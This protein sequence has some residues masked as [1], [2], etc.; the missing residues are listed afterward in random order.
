[1][2]VRYML[3]NEREE[4]L[5]PGNRQL[6][7]RCIFHLDAVHVAQVG[8]AALCYG[9]VVERRAECCYCGG[10]MGYACLVDEG[11]QEDPAE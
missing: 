8:R 6:P 9:H 7:G 11:E 4:G 3:T 2:G 1:M 10:G 5:L